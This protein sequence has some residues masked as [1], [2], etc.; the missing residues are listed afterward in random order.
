MLGVLLFQDLSDS[1]YHCGRNLLSIEN[2]LLGRT[3]GGHYQILFTI[4]E[5]FYDPW[6][7][8]FCTLYDNT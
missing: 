5:G 2:L 6:T 3:S 1:L 4:I 7:W 8:L